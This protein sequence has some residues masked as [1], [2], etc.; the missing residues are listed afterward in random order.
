[1]TRYVLRLVAAALLAATAGLGVPTP[2]QAATCSTARGVTVVVDF[3]QLGGGAQASCDSGGAG[4][5][6]A[7][8]FKDA[9]HTLTYV[10]NEPFVCRVDGVPSSDPCVRTPPA[11]AYWSLWWSD[12]TSGTWHFATTGVASLKVPAG[13]YVALSWQSG[14]AQVPPGVAPKAHPAPSPS[15]SSQPTT[16]PATP[17]STATRTPTMAPTGAPT[18]A[19]TNAPTGAPAS[20]AGTPSA[21]RLGQHHTKHHRKQHSGG[22]HHPSL[23]PSP[24][25]HADA[26]AASRPVGSAGSGLPGWVPPG[27]VALLFAAAAAVFVVRRTRVGGR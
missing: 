15:P 12:G 21:T 14:G 3:H 26:A 18:N 7:A 25:E 11:D 20:S 8:Q 6:A 19:P 2:A 16:A 4:E 13:G 22:H 9:G 23:A 5:Y 24:T 17:T 27:L 10:Q 1:M